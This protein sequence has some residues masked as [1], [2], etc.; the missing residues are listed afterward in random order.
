[1]KKIL[2]SIVWV[3]FLTILLL[4][5]PRLAA[6]IASLFD[7][8]A[9][10]PDGA[11]AWRSV[12]HTV[13]ALIFIILILGINKIKP[14]DYGIGLGN[15]EEGKKRLFLFI[16]FFTIYT[17]GAYITVIVT[18]SFQ[19]FEY[20]LT[21]TNITGHLGFQLLLSGTSEELIFR[22]FAITMLALLIKK[23]VFKGKVSVVNIIAAVIFSLAHIR[24]SFTPFEMQYSLFQVIYATILG[25]FY[26]DVYE[27]SNSVIY[28]MIMHSY[29]NVLMVG[30]SIILSFIL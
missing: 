18:N 14:L 23:R 16:K 24:F 27:K 5:L 12:R 7:Y 6:I 3:L 2:K 4:G 8:Q 29:T 26:G 21:A 9:I 22:A 20:P 30:I 10:D 25:L 17:V 28:P 15:K 11:Y 19:G 1:M 13:Q